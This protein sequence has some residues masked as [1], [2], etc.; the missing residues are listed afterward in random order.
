MKVIGMCMA[1]DS[2]I[3]VM[4]KKGRALEQKLPG[5]K[6]WICSVTCGIYVIQCRRPFSNI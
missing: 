6:S 1:G 4:V 2:G 5:N 3:A